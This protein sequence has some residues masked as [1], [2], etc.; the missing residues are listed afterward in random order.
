MNNNHPP[1]SNFQK[2]ERETGNKVSLA[3]AKATLPATSEAKNS[4]QT[5]LHFLFLQE[6][7]PT[8]MKHYTSPFNLHLVTLLFAT[9]QCP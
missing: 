8:V 9:R 6:I 5:M 1:A 4:K 2:S 7:C 3:L